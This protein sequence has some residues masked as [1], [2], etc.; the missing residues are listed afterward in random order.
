MLK[1]CT[2]FLFLISYF[3]LSEEEEEEE[4]DGNGNWDEDEDGDGDGGSQVRDNPK[5]SGHR[6]Q[7]QQ[8]MP[9]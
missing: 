8:S 9:T 6:R 7:V 3:V 2:V 5:I 1:Q 4:E